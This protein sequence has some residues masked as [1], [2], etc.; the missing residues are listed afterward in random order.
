[1]EEERPPLWE[2]L[3]IDIHIEIMNNIGSCRCNVEPFNTSH[4]TLYHN[5][6][7]YIKDIRLTIYR[8]MDSI[9]DVLKPNSFKS[10]A[11]SLDK[12]I[13]L[14]IPRNGR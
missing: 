13:N 1:M 6:L 2:L 5:P 11:E 4:K 8:F 3:P 14:L 12:K 7:R 9:F 10:L